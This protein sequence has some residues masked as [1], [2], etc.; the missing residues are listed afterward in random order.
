MV[1]FGIIAL[2]L[3]FVFCFYALAVCVCVCVC[4]HMCM[5]MCINSVFLF[6]HPDYL[7]DFQPH[8]LLKSFFPASLHL[9]FTK[10]RVALFVWVGGKIMGNVSVATSLKKVSPF[11]QPLSPVSRHLGRG[12]DS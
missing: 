9:T 11:P 2:V 4:V 6:F 7:L 8:L 3:I 10:C 1:V 12:R 5:L